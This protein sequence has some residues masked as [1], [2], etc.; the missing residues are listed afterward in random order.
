MIRCMPLL[1]SYGTLQ[2]DEVQRR[3]FGR[4]LIGHRD[5]LP[6]YE[7]G[8]V[9]IEDAAVVAATGLTHNADVV[10]NGRADSRVSGTVLEVTDAELAAADLYEQDADYVRITVGLASGKQ[11]WVYHHARSV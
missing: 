8:Q 7:L 9:K 5:E 3:T 11:A 4:S 1:F 6:G 10:F 2:L